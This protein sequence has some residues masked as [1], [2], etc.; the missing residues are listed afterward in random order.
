MQQYFL[1]VH[2]SVF[3]CEFYKNIAYIYVTNM[4]IFINNKRV[5]LYPNMHMREFRLW[6]FLFFIL[7]TLYIPPSIL[8]HKCNVYLKAEKQT[9]FLEV[10]IGIS[11]QNTQTQSLLQCQGRKFLWILILFCRREDIRINKGFLTYVL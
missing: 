7:Y 9:F 3:Y 4:H 5:T 6:L 2:S 1:N 10:S 8:S 11:V